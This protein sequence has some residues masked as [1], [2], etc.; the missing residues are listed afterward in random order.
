MHLLT[1]GEDTDSIFV[2]AYPIT[3]GLHIADSFH[4]DQGT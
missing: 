3:I 4:M 1:T 2:W